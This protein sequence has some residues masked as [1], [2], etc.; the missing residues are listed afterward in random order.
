MK[1]KMNLADNQEQDSSSESE[2]GTDRG[3][4]K[5]Q[6][7]VPSVTVLESGLSG[8]D[9]TGGKSSEAFNDLPEAVK[10]INDLPEDKEIESSS[11]DE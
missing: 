11:D 1:E 2:I 3:N 10:N 7:K 6:T 8:S 5:P 9:S 4:A